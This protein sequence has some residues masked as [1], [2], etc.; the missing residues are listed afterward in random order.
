M[1][2]GGGVWGVGVGGRGSGLV[3][4]DGDGRM[5]LGRRKGVVVGAF[6]GGGL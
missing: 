2:V 3:W 4:V 5:G 6:S 1:R